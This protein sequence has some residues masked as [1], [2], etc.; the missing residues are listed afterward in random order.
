MTRLLHPS[1]DVAAWLLLGLAIR[2]AFSF[3]TGHPFDTEIWL[4]NAY[5]VAHGWNPYSLLP[6]VPGVSFAYTSGAIPSVA[7]LPLWSLLLAGLYQLFA[8]VPGGSR[9]LLYFL[10]KQPPILGDVL[11]GALLFVATQRWGAARPV[12]RRVLAFWMLFPYPILISAVWGQFDSLVAALVIAAL[13]VGSGRNRSGLLGFGI[14][15]K[16]LPVIFLPYEFLRTRRRSR[17][18]VLLALA[19]PGL[20]TAA[21]FAVTGWSL[22]GISGTLSWETH[23]LP[24]GMTYGTL[25]TYPAFTEAV[26]A[27][28]ALV[29]ALGILWIPG[30][31]VGGWW[32]ARRFPG[33][34]PADLLQ[35]LLFLTTLLFL[36][37]WTVNEQYLI[38]LLPLLLLDVALWHPERR[39]LLHATWLL[40]LAFLVVN[41]FFLV[42]FTAPVFP[43]ALPFEFGLQND[44]TFSGVR[45]V[46]LDALGILFSIHLIQVALVVA[47]PRRSAVPWMVRVLRRIGSGSVSRLRSLAAGR[48]G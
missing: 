13:L 12:A 23:G 42:R 22:G 10:V 39:S 31:V 35:A 43:G 21:V 14:L 32:A 25:L 30:L 34:A 41:N 36:L 16:F 17:W 29:L 15:L 33:D 5:Y 19:I 38:Y 48:G 24:Q 9:F 28:S 44:S 7:Y 37:R 20:F 2:E 1:R 45:T 47:D 18:W 4:R 46:I 40:G 8:L 11:L 3:W 27:N 6:P 26:E